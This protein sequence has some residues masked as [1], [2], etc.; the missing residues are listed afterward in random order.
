MNA[1]PTPEEM[2]PLQE[3]L[4]N[5]IRQK[6]VRQVHLAELSGLS[7]K[8]ISQMLTGRVGGSLDAWSI[9]LAATDTV[10]LADDRDQRTRARLEQVLSEHVMGPDA[11]WCGGDEPG[12]CEWRPDAEVP[13]AGPE[14]F[15]RQH[16]AHV[17]QALTEAGVLLDPCATDDD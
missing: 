10:F 6:K 3:W 11:I 4:I 7:E 5:C 8:H 12:P 2:S 15:I 9:L 13:A 17:A 1:R 16:V 14:D